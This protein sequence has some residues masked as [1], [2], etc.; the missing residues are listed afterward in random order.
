MKTTAL[1]WCLVL[2]GVAGKAQVA[3][4]SSTRAQSAGTTLAQPASSDFTPLLAQLQQTTQVMSVD[5]ARLRIDKWKA[6]SATK[7]R[8]QSDA[9][10]IVR[11][12]QTALPG[13][14]DQ[15]RANPRSLA[16]AFTL[17]RNLNVLGD[18][19]VGLVQSAGAFGP[20][21]EY[22]VLASDASDLDKLRHT[23][24]DQVESMA[25]AA[26]SEMARLRTQVAQATALAAAAPPKK[27]I[28]NDE[29][30]PKKTVH[31][32]PAKKPATNPPATTT[33]TPAAPSKQ[34]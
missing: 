26:D 1:V 16:G 28:V 2:S 23:M 3:A 11:N 15:V 27:T 22:E 24:G 12:L 32:K 13:I 31:K 9:D 19:F 25:V 14:M 17:Y 21:N 10:S 8:S 29:A 7:R 34:P 6:D 5:I 4:P 18:V 20:K 30:K 33:S